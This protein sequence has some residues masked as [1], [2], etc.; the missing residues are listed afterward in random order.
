MAAAMDPYHR[1]LGIPPEEQPAHH[2]RLLGIRLFEDDADVIENAADQRM[3]HLRNFQSGKHSDLCARVLNDVS[4]A[5]ICLLN[6]Q[7]K[8]AYDRQLRQQLAPQAGPPA[9]PVAPEPP[10]PLPPAPGPKLPTAQPLPESAR[11]PP[12]PGAGFALVRPP[13]KAGSAPGGV[14]VR[15]RVGAR[16]RSN[17]AFWAVSA[18]VGLLVV[19][20]AVMLARSLSQPAAA[21]TSLVFN[22]PAEDRSDVTLVIDGV[23][24]EMPASGRWAHPCAAGDHVIEVLRPGYR[25]VRQ[26]VRVEPGEQAKINVTWEKADGTLVSGGKPSGREIPPLQSV[27]VLARV[28]PSA[29][30]VSGDWTRRGAEIHAAARLDGCLVLPVRID[31]MGYVLSADFTVREA[32]HVVLCVPV[33]SR[34]LNVVLT[35]DEIQLTKVDGK[36]LSQKY[37]RANSAVRPGTRCGAAVHVLRGPRQA[38]I[39][40]FV[41]DLTSPE[42]V[43][44]GDETLLTGWRIPDRQRPAIGLRGGEVAFDAARVKVLDGKAT[45]IEGREKPLVPEAKPPV[46]PELVAKSKPPAEPDQIV[47]PKPPEE[48]P[49][50]RLPVA[51]EEQQKKILAQ[52]EEIYKLSQADTAAKKLAVAR[53]L[54]GLSQESAGRPAERFVE[55][56]AA[57]KLAG[58]GGDARLMFEMVDILAKDFQ[59]DPLEFKIEAIG[60]LGEGAADAA[61]IQ[62]LVTASDDVIDQALDTGRY[63]VAANLA[64]LAYRVCQKPAGSSSLRKHAHDRNQQIQEMFQSWEQW[65]EAVATLKTNAD[66]PQANLA[67]GRWYCLNMNDW[68]RGLPHLAKGGD[69]A[70]R[71]LAAGD[72]AA[73]PEDA[74]ARVKLA[75][76]WWDAAGK[77]D[78]QNQRLLLHRARTWYKQAR[79]GQISSLLKMKADKRLEEIARLL[80]AGNG[81]P[82]AGPAPVERFEPGKFVDVLP[83]VDVGRD[84][85]E[86]NWQRAGEEVTVGPGASS[87]LALPVTLRGSYDLEAEFV[88]T[89]GHDAVAFVFPVG[90]KQI[91][92]VLSAA[93][94][95]C[96]GMELL[97]DRSA[98]DPKNPTARKPGVIQN[99]RRYKVL[100]GV[101]L[102]GENALID[103]VLNAKKHMRAF[104]TLD[105]L[106]LPLRWNLDD[107]TRPG[108]GAVDSSVKFIRARIRLIDGRASFVKR[109]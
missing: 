84:R 10:P 22:W 21:G 19:L 34:R 26:T 36:V 27:D 31:G 88:R 56:R 42:M 54:F 17:P 20:G 50:E 37:R 12:A 7:K 104:G 49:K 96:N 5:K 101:R 97:H 69:A 51:P 18:I 41:G 2:Y 87:R 72:L 39:S 89:A 79:N 66:D 78:P 25:P 91:A 6:R 106:S 43:W 23:G 75:D 108:L 90:H 32:G 16:R 57:V 70:L 9:A 109:D 63:D 13:D 29:D 100:I 85:V 8:A 103:V 83:H 40:V 76:A 67:A 102:N 53:A 74:A 44:K 92:L 99:G 71:T 73:A 1:W 52:L 28:D 86:G 94:G 80:H 15:V 4:A 81:S 77:A 14:E 98:D 68:E 46:R 3:A 24:V 58:Q 59:I 105:G 48:K 47:T 55:L 107:P 35:E 61:S 62:A 65:Q 38:Q 82:A 30:R 11:P 93:G 95:K 60:S 64:E 33:G 45:W